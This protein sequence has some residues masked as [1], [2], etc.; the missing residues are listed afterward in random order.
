MT[1]CYYRTLLLVGTAPLDHPHSPLSI[2]LGADFPVVIVSIA[3][4]LELFYLPSRLHQ[5]IEVQS[6]SDKLEA[7]GRYVNT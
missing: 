1:L 3:Y 4:L 5:S 6:K 7:A 2:F